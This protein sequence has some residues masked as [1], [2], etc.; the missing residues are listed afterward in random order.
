MQLLHA[1]IVAYRVPT[2]VFRARPWQLAQFQRRT[3]APPPVSRTQLQ[4]AACHNHMLCR[5]TVAG[6]QHLRVSP[7]RSRRRRRRLERIAGCAGLAAAWC[8]GCAAAAAA[9]HHPPPPPAAAA[10]IVA[11]RPA[12]RQRGARAHAPADAAEPRTGRP[13]AAASGHADSVGEAAARAVRRRDDGRRERRVVGRRRR[14]PR[15]DA[16]LARG[17]A[18]RRRRRRRRSRR[19]RRRL[20]TSSRAA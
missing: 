14:V 19:R 10:A 4:R 8:R 3:A 2:I 11:A 9:L 1:A 6:E 5:A 12:R 15:R 16:R 7:P 18:A 17:S 13:T 20:A